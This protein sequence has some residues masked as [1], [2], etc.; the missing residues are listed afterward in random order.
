MTQVTD[1]ALVHRIEKCYHTTLWNAELLS[2]ACLKCLATLPCEILMLEKQ[3]QP[4]MCY[5]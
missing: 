5:Y 3:K 2:P 1:Y 4:E